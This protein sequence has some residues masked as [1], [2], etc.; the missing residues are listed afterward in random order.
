MVLIL[1]EDSV[2]PLP[3]IRYSIDVVIS[4]FRYRTN[5]ADYFELHFFEKTHKERKT[6][7]VTEDA[8][9]FIFLVD[10][11]EDVHKYRDKDQ[12]YRV[13]RKFTKREQL[14]CPPENHSEFEDFLTRHKAVL[15]KRNHAYSGVGIELWS[16]D[17]SDLSILYEKAVKQPAILDELV[18]Q[19]PKLA[20]LNPDTV[21]TVRIYAIMIADI[22]HFIAAE[23]HIGRSGQIVDNYERGGLSAI[24]DLKTGAIIGDA[25]DLRRNP[26]QAHPDTGAPIRNFVLPLWDEVLRFTEECARAC[27]LPCME[28]DIAIREKDCV[29]IEANPNV[30]NCQLQL[31]PSHGRKRQFEDLEKLYRSGK[32]DG[33]N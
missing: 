30:K 25:Y 19:H 13:L 32:S 22:C 28:W 7:F 3:V 20:R 24:V 21:N 16:V 12:M 8:N 33:V 9:R 1:G 2:R 17:D 14:F 31:E 27:P 15:Y 29:L 11:E 26:Y 6:F 4:H 18:I 10:G 5:I 23:F